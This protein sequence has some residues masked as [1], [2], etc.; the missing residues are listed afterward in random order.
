[1]CLKFKFHNFKLIYFWIWIENIC[2][3]LLNIYMNNIAMKEYAEM[4]QNQNVLF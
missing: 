2:I 4:L 3:E 1:M